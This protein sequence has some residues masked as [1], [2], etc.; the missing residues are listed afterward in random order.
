MRQA[1]IPREQTLL[2]NIIPW[3]NG[4]KSV[5]TLERKH[6]LRQVC[7]M[8]HLLPSL[9]VVVLVGPTVA[10]FSGVLLVLALAVTLNARVRNA[11]RH[12]G[13]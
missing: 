11:P 7:E 12:S 8:T 5:E 4:T 2:W 10:V 13:L 6:G 9:R 3:W 1:D